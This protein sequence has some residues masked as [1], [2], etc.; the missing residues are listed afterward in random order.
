[1]TLVPMCGCGCT[2]PLRPR[3][4][5]FIKGRIPRTK[6]TR[7]TESTIPGRRVAWEASRSAANART[8]Q[9]LGAR[10][11]GPTG[12]I[13]RSNNSYIYLR[14][15]ET[16]ASSRIQCHRDTAIAHAEA[17]DKVTTSPRAAPPASA[18]AR[19]FGTAAARGPAGSASPARRPRRR[20]PGRP[21]SSSRSR[22]SRVWRRRRRMLKT[23]STS[24]SARRPRP[25]CPSATT[26]KS[27]Q[28]P[29]ARR[30]IA[31]LRLAAPRR[32]SHAAH[33]WQLF[34][35]C[36]RTYM[37]DNA[38]SARTCSRLACCRS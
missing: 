19:I 11:E 32:P 2:T 22:C 31:A 1:M 26:T 35:L 9:G 10:D 21:A 23:T 12:A 4:P 7:A 15:A 30:A 20:R 38:N 14:A 16:A 6:R 24:R 29:V 8:S 33:C 27:R 36:G 28:P 3:G 18:R 34:S 17:G 13:V 37:S 5:N 25:R